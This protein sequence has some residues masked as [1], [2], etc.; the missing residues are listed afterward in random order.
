[1]ILPNLEIFL[2][3]QRDDIYYTNNNMKWLYDLYCP[4]ILYRA[5]DVANQ[6]NIY[7]KKMIFK[8]D[9]IWV[10]MGILRYMMLMRL[11][12]QG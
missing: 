12:K 5:S 10:Q 11:I 7:S 6:W 3:G 9:S 2:D 1:M 4:H 8:T